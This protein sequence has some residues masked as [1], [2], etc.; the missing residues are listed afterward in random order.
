MALAWL[1]GLMTWIEFQGPPLS[2]KYLLMWLSLAMLVASIG[3]PLGWAKSMMIDWLPLYFLLVSYDIAHGLVDNLG[4]RPHADPQLSFD[5]ALFGESG[6]TYLLQNWLW[7]DTPSWYDHFFFVVYLS[8]FVVS[9][10]VCAALWIRSRHDFLAY[11]RRIVGTWLLAL[12]VFAAYPTVPPWM[13]AEQGHLPAM[14]RIIVVLMNVVASSPTDAAMEAGDGR[15]SLA[16]PVAAVPS[17]HAALP[18]LLLLFLWG[19][20]RR[21]R[22][23]LLAYTVLM[24]FVLV[25][26]GEHYVFD[27]LAGWITAILVHAAANKLEARRL[28]AAQRVGDDVTRSA[29]KVLVESG[30]RRP[31]S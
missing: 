27:I 3:N 11:R 20:A 23:V 24:G 18:M 17:M 1:I 14:D 21:L 2:L 28:S 29:A 6:P 9:L 31:L 16:N 22:M 8:H 26:T 12:V 7:F 13:A 15:I 25:Y 10:A 5:Q 30:T 4:V 19:R